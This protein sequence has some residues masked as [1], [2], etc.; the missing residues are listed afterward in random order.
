MSEVG[1]MLTFGAVLLL[2]AL[3]GG[4]FGVKELTVPSVPTWARIVCGI[5]GA[6]LVAI[7]VYIT[8]NTADA[9]ESPPGPSGPEQRTTAP[10][11]SPSFAID[12]AEPSDTGS[13]GPAAYDSYTSVADDT[14]QLSLEVPTAWSHRRSN[15]WFTNLPRVDSNPVGPGVNAAPNVEDWSSDLTTPGIFLGSSRP[16]AERYS[17]RQL[18]AAF[19]FSSCD[20]VS[21]EQYAR[22]PLRGDSATWL[23]EGGTR[24]YVLAAEPDEGSYIVIVQAKL[25]DARD[26]DALDRGLRS[27]DVTGAKCDVTEEGCT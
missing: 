3:V 7:A 21:E 15:G 27:I 13:P 18:A 26:S 8:L 20:L 9:N 25:V 10:V 23:C 16:L 14:G 2:I 17:T 22:P 24:W 4:G 11:G 19:S 6:P 5:V 12:E 1:V